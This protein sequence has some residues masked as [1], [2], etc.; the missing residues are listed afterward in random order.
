MNQLLDTDNQ[1]KHK[2]DSDENSLFPK[3]V[4]GYCTC[5]SNKQILSGSDTRM[6]IRFILSGFAAKVGILR[7]N[8]HKGDKERTYL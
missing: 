8:A 3:A 5:Q 7:I 2:K 1:Q 4:N 6:K